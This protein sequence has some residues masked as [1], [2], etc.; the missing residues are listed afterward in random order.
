MEE[1]KVGR[2]RDGLDKFLDFAGKRGLINRKT[3]DNRRR[4][5]EAILGILDEAEAADLSKIN[6][7][8]VILR[9]RTIAAGLIPPSSLRGYESH[10]RGAVRDFLEYVKNPSAWKPSVQQ[11]A[12]RA[13]KA[14]PSAR[15]S[16]ESAEPG[17]GEQPPSPRVHIDFHIHIAP[18]ATPG[19]IDKIFESMS[20]HFGSRTD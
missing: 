5:S 15:K 10:V 12:S 18:E 20:H 2:S 3:V 8:D 13:A 1:Q 6:L 7:E 14:A 16:K 19:Q 11:R 17:V 4:A 9:H